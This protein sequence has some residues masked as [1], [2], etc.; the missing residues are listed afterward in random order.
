MKN[1]SI[2]ILLFA[3]LFV[4]ACD[5]EDYTA[6]DTLSDVSWYTG[7]HPGNLYAVNLG[8]YISFMDLSQ[9]ELSHEWSIEDGNN[10]LNNEFSDGD[11]LINF[12]LEDASLTTNETTIHVLFNNPGLNKVRLYNTFNDSVTYPGTIPFGSVRKGDVWVIDTA[13]VVDVYEAIKPEV[14]IYQDDVLVG[15]VSADLDPLEEEQATWDTIYV[16]AGSSLKYVD[17]TTVGRSTKRTWNLKGAKFVESKNIDSLA[18]VHYFG[19]GSY[20]GSITTERGISLPEGKVAKNIPYIVKVI[21]SSQPFV[22]VNGSFSEDDKEVISFNVSGEVKDFDGEEAN[23]TAHVE[24]AS[25]GFSQDITVIS[26]KVNEVDRTK[27]DLKFA[28]AIYNTDVVTI[29]YAGGNI[30]SVDER[31]LEAFTTPQKVKMNL[32]DSGLDSDWAGFETFKD[33]FKNAFCE[34]YFAGKNNGT[35]TAPIFSRVEGSLSPSG[36]PCMSY[37]N[38]DGVKNLVLQGSSFKDMLPDE[39][40][41][42]YQISFELYIETGSNLTKLTTVVLDPSTIITWDVTG[43]EE[44]KWVTLSQVVS[45]ATLPTKRYD[46]K[47]ISAD[48]PDAGNVKLYFDDYSFILLEERP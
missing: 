37:T 7:I 15:S 44:G 40:S 19:L 35:A 31:I 20:T 46:L 41:Y 3:M 22:A 25:S 34:G 21:Q 2:I 13:L 8:E 18:I 29:T 14:K 43:V 45:F 4:V 36:K 24:N 10:Y 39:G 17:A 6:P 5:E 26:V 33:N 42:T 12:I 48:N 32:P 27:L 1:I 30:K 23:F 28:E 11:S 47:M 9:G 38:A 16:E